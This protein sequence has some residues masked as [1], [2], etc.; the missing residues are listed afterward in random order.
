MSVAV[1]LFVF[2]LIHELGHAMTALARGVRAEKIIL[3]PLGG[4][5]HI[6]DRPKRVLD[7]VLVYAAGPGANLL[8]A[9]LALPALLSNPYGELILRSTFNPTG[10]FVL[11][12]GLVDQLLSVTVAVNVLLAAGNLL[13]AFP[14]DGG[15]ILHALLR[16]RTGERTATVIISVL[17]VIIGTALVYLGYRLSD[18]LLGIGAG[19]IICMSIVALRS[20]WQRRRLAKLRIDGLVRPVEDLSPSNRLYVSDG[21]ARAVQAFAATGW[22]VLPVYDTW[23]DLRGF[24][25]N[26]AVQEE[27][28]TGAGPLIAVAE[29]EF[30]TAQ[31]GENL[32]TVTERIVE[33]NVYGAA[34]F[35]ARGHII[36]FLFTEDVMGVL[37]KN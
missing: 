27:D 28:P 6:P 1:L 24:V 16:G 4:G 25:A 21:A 31:P 34:V 20:G 13:P 35:G 8:V 5:A 33:A 37:G 7:E 14:L 23:N 3:F 12:P 9:A 2:V 29:L 15:R 26:E 19:F 22:P 17:G 11:N 30:A 36:G 32:L 18:P 10:N